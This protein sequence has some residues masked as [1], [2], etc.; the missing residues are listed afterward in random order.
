[1]LKK[2][3]MAAFCVLSMIGLVGCQKNAANEHRL[4]QENQQLKQ[5]IEELQKPV[6]SEQITQNEPA[7]V[8]IVD[9]TTNTIIE[10]ISPKES[11]YETN[12]QAYQQLIEQVAKELGVNLSKFVTRLSEVG[13]TSAASIPLAMAAQ[14]AT[15]TSTTAQASDPFKIKEG[16]VV[17]ICGFGAGLSWGAAIVR[18]GH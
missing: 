14:T 17:A 11:G 5:Q 12:P 8:E 1:M 7:I 18:W 4:E 15:S 16:D 13:N 10:T 9:P 2:K 6:N 3:W